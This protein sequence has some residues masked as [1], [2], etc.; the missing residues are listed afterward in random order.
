MITAP[1]ACEYGDMMAERI[2]LFARTK[3][4][5]NVPAWQEEFSF[6]EELF[7]ED[8]CRYAVCSSS[9]HETF[10]DG[11][12]QQYAAEFNRHFSDDELPADADSETQAM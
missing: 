7:A 11:F 2:R 5:M 9:C 6:D 4:P 12:L 10:W 1:I 8:F 3:V